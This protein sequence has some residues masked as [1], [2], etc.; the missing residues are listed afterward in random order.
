MAQRSI[1]ILVYGALANTLAAAMTQCSIIFALGG[2]SGTAAT[3][4]TPTQN[5]TAPSDL[6][7]MDHRAFALGDKYSSGVA[8]SWRK[9]RS[10]LKKRM[11]PLQR[12]MAAFKTRTTVEMIWGAVGSKKVS[13]T[14]TLVSM[15]M[16]KL[17]RA[18][19]IILT[20]EQYHFYQV[21]SPN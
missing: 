19:A 3:Q 5:M 13:P 10:G 4:R 7:A 6:H 14:S 12:M 11:V 1:M 15:V 8:Q 9:K 2:K 18:S 20:S 21:T 17:K 16:E